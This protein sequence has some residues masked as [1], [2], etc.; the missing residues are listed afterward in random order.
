[1]QSKQQ[2]LLPAAAAFLL[3]YALLFLGRSAD[4]NA[5][6][7]WSWSFARTDARI[8]YLVLAAGLALSALLS[9]AAVPDRFHI[10]LLASLSFVAAVPFWTEPELI[11]DASRYF[12]QAK[13]LE[14]YGISYFFREWGR[15]ITA[16]TDLPLV[17]FLYGLVFK[18]S[19][20]QRVAIQLFTTLLFSLTAV[21]TCLIG[22]RLWDRETGFS[23]GLLLLGM[24]Y[25]LTQ[26]PLMLVDV[27]TMFFLALSTFSFIAALERGGIG[28]ASL[29]VAAIVCAAMS[30][31]SAWFMLSILP[32]ALA[33]RVFRTPRPDRRPALQRGVAILAAAALATGSVLLLAWDTVSG[34]I[35]LLNDFQKPGLARWSESFVST[36]LFQIH[37][38]V[39]LSALLSAIVAI[40]RRDSRYLVVSW[41]LLLVVIFGIRRIRYILPVF[42][43]LALMAALGIQAV[44]HGRLRRFLVYGVVSSSLTIAVLAYLPFA[45]SMNAGNLKHAGAYLDTL[46]AR[47]I[48]V[49]TVVPARTVANP[50][51]SVPLL[52]LFTAKQVRY[53]YRPDAVLPQ[54]DV[55]HSSLRFTWEYRNPAYYENANGADCLPVVILSAGKN[56]PQPLLSRLTGFRLIKAFSA[57]D[58]IFQY[59]LGVSIYQKDPGCGAE[60]SRI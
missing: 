7:S 60:G 22:S 23:G 34:Q 16:W 11:L 41:L 56:L 17:P 3:V 29:S 30:K 4:D 58:N 24:P 37:P 12:T 35:A 14:L 40:R 18:V 59:R 51:V 55:E 10:P 6:F 42:P 28:P 47:E 25:L 26:V 54:E 33:V 44:G 52:D 13:H 20:E 49:M 32:A 9:R 1:M 38:F 46:E 19:G 43:M 31:Y 50:S 27:P 53:H 57:D 5:L 39:T 36:F 21:L 45:R 48:E 2:S 15:T 8:V